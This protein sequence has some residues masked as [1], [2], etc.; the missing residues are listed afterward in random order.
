MLGGSQKYLTSDPGVLTASSG[1]YG[2]CTHMH[3][4][5]HTHKIK[6]QKNWKDSSLLRALDVF[7]EDLCSPHQHNS[8][9]HLISE[10]PAPSSDLLWAPGIRA[11]HM[12]IHSQITHTCK[13][14]IKG[15]FK[16]KQNL[17]I[18]FKIFLMLSRKCSWLLACF[19]PSK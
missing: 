9:Q 12:R 3:I 17:K 2:H 16:N 19:I 14:K 6:K 15:Y 4:L 1:L 18:N 5:I 10:G 8:I 13:I 11:V 7:A